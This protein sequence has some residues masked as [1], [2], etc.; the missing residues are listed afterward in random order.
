[1]GSFTVKDLK[2]F[3]PSRRYQSLSLLVKSFSF[4]KFSVLPYYYLL[5]DPFT[6]YKPYKSPTVSVSLPLR[7]QKN[8]DNPR[9]RTNTSGTPQSFVGETDHHPPLV[10]TDT[11]FRSFVLISLLSS[12]ILTPTF[13]GPYPYLSSFKHIVKHVI[14]RIFVLFLR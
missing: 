14:L 9:P 13:P 4:V 12:I 11:S 7:H 3:S 10:D 6:S 8:Q 2:P 5:K 1:M